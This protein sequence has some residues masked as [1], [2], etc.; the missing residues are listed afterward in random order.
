MLTLIGILL[1]QDLQDRGRHIL[2]TLQGMSLEQQLDH[3][4]PLASLF[5]LDSR[6][7]DAGYFGAGHVHASRANVVVGA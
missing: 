1:S 2:D 6:Y 3:A 4:L 7:G 5:G